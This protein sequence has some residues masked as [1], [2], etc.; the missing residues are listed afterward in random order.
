MPEPV[1]TR[2]LH[3][4]ALCGHVQQRHGV[5]LHGTPHVHKA[6]KRLRENAEISTHLTKEQR[7]GSRKPLTQCNNPTKTEMSLCP[8]CLYKRRLEVRGGPERRRCAR[9][10]CADGVPGCSAQTVQELEPE[11]RL[12]AVAERE[13]L[14]S[15]GVLDHKQRVSAWRS[16]AELPSE[17]QSVTPPLLPPSDM[18]E[19]GGGKLN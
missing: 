14:L 15:T 17:R 12:I 3:W 11:A 4:S 8:S 7:P 1:P 13:Q 6:W 5:S 2:D 10:L 16:E 18:E 9:L 19:N